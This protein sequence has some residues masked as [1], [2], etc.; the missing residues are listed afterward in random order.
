MGIV[1][2]VQECIVL[3]HI[4]GSMGDRVEANGLHRA[5]FVDT[6][7]QPSDIGFAVSDIFV[8]M[9]VIRTYGRFRMKSHGWID[10]LIHR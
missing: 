3:D 7:T 9:I 4:W 6:A 5:F 1:D 8:E 10:W 2:S